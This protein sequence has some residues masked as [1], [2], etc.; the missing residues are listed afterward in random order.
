M[1]ALALASALLVWL[2]FIRDGGNDDA[3]QRAQ[4]TVQV[5][6][7]D[8]LLDAL[9]GVGY[10]VYWVGS[11]EGVRYE[12]T[13]ISDGRTYVRYLPSGAEQESGDAFRTVGSYSVPDAYGR[14]KA[15]AERPSAS[16]FPLPG[17]GIALPNGD[18]PRSVYVA[19]PGV[20]VQIEVYDPGA[21]RAL[22]LVK[23]VTPI[24]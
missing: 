18:D 14:I 9:A 3:S 19:F 4:K 5:V 20:D 16:S 21:G 1:I 8:Q 12:V 10:P 17:K 15:L 7:A 22:Q 11:Q 6:S 13:R 24:G 23:S 2:L